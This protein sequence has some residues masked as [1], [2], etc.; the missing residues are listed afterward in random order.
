MGV[1]GGHARFPLLL[2]MSSEVTTF[3]DV[4]PCALL[5][6]LRVFRTEF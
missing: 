3:V 6:V 4:K 1:L 5:G 2:Q